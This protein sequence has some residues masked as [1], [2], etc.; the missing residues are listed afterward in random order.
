MENDKRLVFGIHPVLELLK[1]S[2]GDVAEVLLVSGAEGAGAKMVNEAAR[3]CGV[4]VSH[5]HSRLMDEMA[6]GKKHQGVMAQV[7]GSW[8]LRMPDLLQR[9]VP[10]RAQEWILILDGLTDPRNFGA[11]LRTAE[12]VGIEHIVIPKDRAVG[13]TPTVVKASAGA[14]H[15]LKIYQ[16]T[17]L[18]RAMV[19]LK[20]HGYWMVGLDLQSRASIYEKAFPDKLGIIL[21]GEGQGIR[22]LILKECDF[23]VSIPMAGKIASL[24]VAVAGAVFLYELVRQSKPLTKPGTKR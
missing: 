10:G 9:L 18:R 24:N 12:A 6:G 1:G 21:G 19:S 17:N 4:A 22:P 8:I 3:Q 7:R 14:V 2:A 11:L 5:V 23:H 15:H 16:A 13:V 20:E